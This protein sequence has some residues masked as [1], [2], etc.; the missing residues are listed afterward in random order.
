M[1]LELVTKEPPSVTHPTPILFV[2]GMWHAAWCWEEHFLSYY[3][4]H[5]YVVHALSLRGHGASEGRERLRWTSL[6][7][8][9]SDVAQVAGQMGRIPAMAAP[10]LLAAS[11]CSMIPVSLTRFS[12]NSS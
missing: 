12:P 11:I 6:A 2:H 10:A 9:V 8:Y 4:D 3:A 1:R 5:G 7:D